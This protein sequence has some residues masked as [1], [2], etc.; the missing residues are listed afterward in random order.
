MKDGHRREHT[1]MT[2][3]KHESGGG[4]KQT[5]A[6]SPDGRDARFS[7]LHLPAIVG[8]KICVWVVLVIRSRSENVIS[9]RYEEESVLITPD[10]LIYI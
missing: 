10:V 1:L 2:T 3:V 8:R 9:I 5:T 7:V 6:A 4:F